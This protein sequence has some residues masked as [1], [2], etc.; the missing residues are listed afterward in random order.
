MVRISSFLRKN[1]AIDLGTANTLIHVGGIGIVVN[2]PTYI[3]LDENG[4]VVCLGH[5]AYRRYGKTPAGHRIHRPLKDGVIEDFDAATLLIKGFIK[6][7]KAQ[8]RLLSPR[9]LIGI[10]SKMTQ[11]EKRSVL[12]A[13]R[14]SNIK[15][16]YLIEETMAASIGAGLDVFGDIP[17]M[18]VDIGGGTTEAALIK[19]GAFLHVDSVRVAGDEMDY[20]IRKHLRENFGINI[21]LRSCEEIKWKIGSA[22]ENEEWEYLTYS[23]SGKDVKTRLPRSIT[24]TPQDIRPALLPILEEISNFL[25]S[26]ILEIEPSDSEILFE[27]GITLTGGG[28][29]L[30]GMEIY[31]QEVLEL[32]VKSVERPLLAVVEGAGIAIEEL[33]I[34]RSCFA[35]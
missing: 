3:E 27:N 15:N 34:Y 13:A 4:E 19:K 22:E 14:Q 17:F 2:E 16:P 10:P 33:D 25:K 9:V 11:M 30:K 21:G 23:V 20:A 26:F 24:L 6:K 5:E 28:S 7:A 29:L 8:K 31:L 32:P 12:E 18:I 35:N 1:L